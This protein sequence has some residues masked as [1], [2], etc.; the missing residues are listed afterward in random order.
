MEHL[1]LAGLKTL[2]NEIKSYVAD[3][4]GTDY[5]D[6][7]WPAMMEGQSG[8]VLL[9]KAGS[10][11]GG[12]KARDDRDTIIRLTKNF[13]SQYTSN[14]NSYV[15]KVLYT[16]IKGIGGYRTFWLCE[17]VTDILGTRYWDTS[18]ITSMESMFRSCKKLKEVDCSLWDTSKVTN[19]SYM[20]C[21]CSSVAELDVSGF[22]TS[23]VTDM[24]GMFASCSSVAELD[25]SGFDTSNVTDMGGMFAS[26]SLLTEIDVSG[27]DVSSVTNTDGMFGN[28]P[29][30][31]T[32][33]LSGWKTGKLTSMGYNWHSMFYGCS[34]LTSLD[35][36][37]FDTSGVTDVSFLFCGCTSLTSLDVS[38]WDTSAVTNMLSMFSSCSS[39]ASLD[40]SG[41]DTS[42]VTNMNNMFGRCSSLRYITLGEGFFKTTQPLP[43]SDAAN[44]GLNAD[45][46]DN[47]WLEHLATVAPTV[48]DGTARTIQLP[49]KVKALSGASTHIATLTDKGYT[50]A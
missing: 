25:V 35:L 28:C 15:L 32:L 50:V 5:T 9:I 45:G 30:L 34:S 26:C 46:T 38:T 10:T 24:G 47:G 18:G 23:N 42:S 43:F 3:N 7:L 16:N 12:V 11:V 39:L 1:D 40:L 6:E 13:M 2:V 33:N 49:S 8:F 37:G 19:M 48:T 22:D 41:F 4:G 21:G 20:F 31:K 14:N 27:W 17:E 36:S 29:S 44:L